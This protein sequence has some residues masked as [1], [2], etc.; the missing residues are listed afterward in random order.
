MAN[1]RLQGNV[2]RFGLI[3]PG[4]LS[5]WTAPTS[6]ELNAN[7]TNNP[8]GLVF[9][10]TCALD[11]D[12]TSFSLDDPEMDDSHS[13]CQSASDEEPTA[14]N[15]TVSFSAFRAT[16]EGKIGNPSVWNTAHLAFTLLAW[17]GV[18]YYAF[19]SLGESPE[20][21]FAPGQY[22]DLVKVATN[23]GTD[24]VG[25][26]EPVRITQDFAFRGDVN[27]NYKLLA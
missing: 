20:A 2:Y 13:F 10:L 7:P 26:G 22:I 15:V 12:N 8:N 11:V 14:D 4:G 25:T 17:R 16:G 5:D 18:E 1:D 24:E 27:W 21:G 9:N 23:W 3:L 6:A 19:R